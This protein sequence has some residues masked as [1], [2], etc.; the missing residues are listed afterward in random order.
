MKKMVIIGQIKCMA[1]LPRNDDRI[2]GNSGRIRSR[3]VLILN[4]VKYLVVGLSVKL[5]VGFLK[6]KFLDKN[7][8]VIFYLMHN[9]MN[10]NYF[11]SKSTFNFLKI[12]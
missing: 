5:I 8:H 6:C 12:L 1:V 7:F 11:E 3:Y 4:Q 9:I 10:I 2:G